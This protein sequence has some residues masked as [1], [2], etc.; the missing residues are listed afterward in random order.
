MRALVVFYSRTGNTRK[1]AQALA[2]EL[3]AEAEKINE[4]ETRGGLLGYLLAGRDAA[5]KRLTP[6]EPLAFDPAAYDLVVLGTPVWAWTMASPVRTFLTE[7][8]AKLK[9]VAF[10]CT[11]GGS[12]AERAFRQMEELAGRKPVATLALLEKELK[13]DFG[14]KVKE[15]AKKLTGNGN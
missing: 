12:G 14:A 9:G 2:R 8:A 1:V 3:G 13:G 10:F 4:P 5:L 6:I 15:F 11:Q 7:Q